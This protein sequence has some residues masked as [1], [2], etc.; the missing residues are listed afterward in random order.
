MTQQPRVCIVQPTPCVATETFLQ[1]H[2]D[3]LPAATSVVY[4]FKTIRG[5]SVPHLAG[6]P[7]LSQ[8][9]LARGVRKVRR[10]LS[11]R[12]RTW[13]RTLAFERVFR[14]VGA[15]AVLAEYGTTGV[16]VMAAAQRLGIPL[17]VHFHGFDASRKKVLASHG[18][19]YRR[20]FR[21]ASAVVCVSRVMEKQ[22]LVLGAH[23]DRLHYNPYGVDCDQFKL[24]RPEEMAPHFLAVGRFVDKKAPHLT[25]SAFARVSRQCPESRLIMVGDGP[26]LGSC[27]D[28]ATGLGIAGSVDFLGVQDHAAV[29]DKMRQCRCFVQHSVLAED[30]DCEGTPNTILEAMASGLPVVATRHAGIPDVVIEGETGQLVEER[31]IEGMADHLLKM[32]L[33]PIMARTFGL[34]GRQRVESHYSIQDSIDALWRIIESA[35]LRNNDGNPSNPDI[36]KHW[37]SANGDQLCSVS[38]AE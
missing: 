37:N 27:R 38:G 5:E 17:I 2:A 9:V 33:N 22:L 36:E 32:A 3:R 23:E 19:E 11:G 8:T 21:I 25:I 14:A 28:L 18:D 30:G 26:L 10:T 31:D 29:A 24:G 1:A 6:R 12:P 16:Q 4:D 15:D 35:I 7:V 20:L 13:L 34:A